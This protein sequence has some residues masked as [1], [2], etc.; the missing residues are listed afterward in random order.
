MATRVYDIVD[1]ILQDDTEVSLRPLPIGQLR[2]FMAAWE[3]MGDIDTETDS[4]VIFVTCAGIA[5]ENH[6][7]TTN[8]FETTRGTEDDPLSEQYRT[9]LEGVLDMDTIFKVLEICGGLKLNDPKLLEALD[10]MANP[11]ADGTS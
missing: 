4:F 5:L 8:K 7:K 3:K 11:A 9:Y 6:F 10:S 1:I 2:R